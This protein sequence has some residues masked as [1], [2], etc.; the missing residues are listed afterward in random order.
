M[1]ANFSEPFT[2]CKA[3]RFLKKVHF[4]ANTPRDKHD[5]Y[6]VFYFIIYLQQSTFPSHCFV[7]SA[8]SGCIMLQIQGRH[9]LGY[10]VTACGRGM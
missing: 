10:L 9:R 8:F 7:I 5:K 2:I 3:F 1:A 4:I 6:G